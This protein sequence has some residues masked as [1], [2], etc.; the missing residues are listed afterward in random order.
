MPFTPRERQLLA[1]VA[2]GCDNLQIGAELGWAD[3]TV[4][5]ALSALYKRLAVEGRSHAV[6]RARELGFR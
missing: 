4:R 5:N 2:R 6:V 3:K 1:L